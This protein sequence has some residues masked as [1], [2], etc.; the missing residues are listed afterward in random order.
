VLLLGVLDVVEEDWSVV[1]LL[2]ACPNGTKP[3]STNNAAAKT[4]I[5]ARGHFISILLSPKS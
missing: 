4:S 3:K 1:A 2:C 5:L